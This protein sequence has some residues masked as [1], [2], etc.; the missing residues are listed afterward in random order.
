[1]LIKVY[2]ADETCAEDETYQ[3]EHEVTGPSP[4]ELRDIITAAAVHYPDF[5]SIFLERIEE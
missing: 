3:S 2:V 4:D 1:M 5:T